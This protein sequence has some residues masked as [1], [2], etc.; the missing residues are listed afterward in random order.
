M[1]FRREQISVE[2]WPQVH[3]LL[4]PALEITGEHVSSLIDLLLANR[5]QLWV[6]REGGD[7]VAAAVSEIEPP[8]TLCIRLMGGKNIASWI[9]EAMAVIRDNAPGFRIRA[10]VIPALERVLREHGFTKTRVM[11]ERAGG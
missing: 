1:T 6:K 8:D 9:D 2:T 5:N 4:A 7:P 11:M 10:E 3:A